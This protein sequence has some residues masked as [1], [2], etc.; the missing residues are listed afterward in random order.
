MKIVISETQRN[1]LIEGIFLSD[2]EKK[3]RLETSIE[4]AKD[5]S[6]PRQFSLEHPKL[7]RG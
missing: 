4:L 1:N 3:Q 2:E 6:R 5:Y 7:W